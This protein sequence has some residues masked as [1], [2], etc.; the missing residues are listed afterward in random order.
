V[1]LNLIIIKNKL[2]VENNKNRSLSSAKTH[3]VVVPIEGG[4]GR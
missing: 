4:G 3:R 1:V 2:N